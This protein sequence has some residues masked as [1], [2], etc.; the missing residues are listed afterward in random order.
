MCFV[1]AEIKIGVNFSLKGLK[2]NRDIPVFQAHG[3]EDPLVPLQWGEMTGNIVKQMSS[4]HTFK[5]YPMVHSS[6]QEVSY[7]CLALY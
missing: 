7:N 4:K 1:L 5:T 6:C 2:A 3:T